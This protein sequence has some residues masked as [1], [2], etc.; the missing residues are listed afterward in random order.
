[1]NYKNVWLIILLSLIVIVVWA[2]A[3]V[4][5][6]QATKEPFVKTTEPEYNFQKAHESFLKKDFKAAAFEIRKGAEFMKK[7][8][9]TATVEGNMSI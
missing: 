9:E 5:G 7:E 3:P 4:T 6:A 1:M 8:T 2:F